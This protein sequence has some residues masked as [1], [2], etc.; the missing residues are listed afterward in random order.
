MSRVTVLLLAAL[1]ISLVANL[2]QWEHARRQ[3][4]AAAPDAR[5]RYEW[6]EIGKSVGV[7]DPA[8]GEM[9][10]LNS[11]S[12]PPSVVCLDLR[13]AAVHTIDIERDAA[14]DGVPL[15]SAE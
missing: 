9:F 13:K 8:S 4:A 1:G 6:R 11:K 14:S 2:G 7:F 10:I 15:L 3:A 5:T 12:V